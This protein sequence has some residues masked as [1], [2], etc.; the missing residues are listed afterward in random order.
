MASNPR[1]LNQD[2]TVT[3]DG[4]Q[5]LVRKGTIVDVPAGSSL[6]TAYGSGNLTA[7]TAQQTGGDPGDSEPADFEGGG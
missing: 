5:F 6:E 1:E 4:G 3:W 7:L 2:V